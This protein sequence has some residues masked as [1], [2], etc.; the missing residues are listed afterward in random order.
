M[1][2]TGFS[3]FVHGPHPANI[4]AVCCAA[5]LDMSGILPAGQPGNIFT[6]DGQL[7][8]GTTAATA[9]GT[10]T[11]ISTLTAGTGITI[12]NGSG[13]ITIASTASLTDL[14]VARFIVASSTA[15]TGANFTTI[16]AAI[17]AAQGTGINSTVFIQPGTYTENVT[18]V[19]GINLVAFNCDSLT[20]NVTIVGKLTLTTTGTVSISGIRLQTNSDFAIAVTGTLASVLN[21]TNCYINCTN[22]TGISYSSSNASSGIN[23]YNCVANTTTTGIALYASSS[24]GIISFYHCN[25]FNTGSSTTASTCSAGSVTSLWSTWQ[26]PLTFTSTSGLA[27]SYSLFNTSTTNTTGLTFGGTTGSACSDCKWS[28]GTASAISVGTGAILTIMNSIISSSNTNAITGLGTISYGEMEIGSSLTINTTTQ[29][30][31]TTGVGNL[32]IY[33]GLIEHYVATAVSYQVLVTDV[34]IGVTSNAS[35]R[36]I[37]MPNAGLLAGQRW[38]IKDEAGTAQ[39]ANNITISGNGA[40]IDGAASFVINTNFGCV[41]IYTN[42]T[43]FFIA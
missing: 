15:G 3:G 5:N 35:A 21:L 30:P 12:T 17:A 25:L 8:I 10:H 19:P 37:T 16:S 41:D 9:G 22:N 26:H 43:N 24:T 2:Y 27:F 14:H 28:S 38:T 23:L 4:P 7:L 11:K 18:L 20:P 39:S 13:A 34:I 40:N 29:T 33:G 6:T 31:G 42:G 36:T 32:K 1:T